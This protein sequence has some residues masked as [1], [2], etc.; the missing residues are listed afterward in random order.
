[1][2]EASSWL[3]TSGI[4][5][6]LGPFETKSV[7]VPPRD[8]RAAA[9][10]ILVDHGVLRLHRVDVAPRDREA[11]SLQLARGVVEELPDGRPAPVSGWRPFET[12]MWTIEPWF[13]IRPPVGD[14]ATTVSGV[15]LR[16]DL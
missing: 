12:L 5:A 15:L 6:C 10:R 14:W 1:M 8:E 13:T 2:A 7:T 9:A 16:E 3:V 4:V 11:R